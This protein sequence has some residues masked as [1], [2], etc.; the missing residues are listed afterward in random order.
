MENNVNTSKSYQ[1]I[2]QRVELSELSSSSMEQLYIMTFNEKPFEINYQVHELIKL[3]K[4]GS[5]IEEAISKCNTKFNK[6]YTI[7]IFQE[8]LKTNFIS[9]I[10]LD[11]QN[12]K[13]KT[14]AFIYAKPII[15]FEALNSLTNGLK[16]TFN[17][18]IFWPIVFLALVLQVIF[19]SY[20]VKGLT[21]NVNESR[22][23]FGYIFSLATILFHELG[24]ATACRFYNTKHGP[25]GVGLYMYFPVFYTDVTSTWKLNR[26][27]RSIIDFAGIYFQL[28]I[29]I[30]II[31]IYL[32]THNDLLRYCVYMTNFSILLNINPFLKFDGYWLVSDM[33]GVPNLRSRTYELVNYYVEKIKG[34]TTQSKPF[35]FQMK[36]VEKWIM[37]SY[38]LF[39]NVFFV[40]F[41]LFRLPIIAYGMIIKYPDKILEFSNSIL[42]LI[43]GQETFQF[44]IF[45]SFL[46]SSM[47]MFFTL[48]IIYISLKK[49]I[50]SIMRHV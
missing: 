2:L 35:L 32:Y 20:D 22:L 49:G 10:E 41:F 36:P 4:G 9:K 28:I 48:Y 43:E 15:S 29:V 6:Q 7:G 25:I 34:S 24:H 33:L 13:S 30:P 23:L 45:M 1:E 8:W 19:Y 40:Y 31:A 46:F 39:T 44:S 5:S 26:F 3:V 21:Q 50:A 18:K 14:G 27:Q 42:L 47:F 17:K 38:V 37:F 16:F 12:I 11:D